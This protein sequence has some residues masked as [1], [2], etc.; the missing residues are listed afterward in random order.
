[1]KTR[2]L[3]SYKTRG[4]NGVETYNILAVRDAAKFPS[5]T[6]E[7]KQLKRML[8]N[9]FEGSKFVRVVD[10]SWENFQGDDYPLPF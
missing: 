3:Y 2:T 5:R 8:G 6:K 1:M 4:Y 7:W 9:P 10:I